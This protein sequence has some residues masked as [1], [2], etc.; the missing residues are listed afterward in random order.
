MV[1]TNRKKAADAW[2]SVRQFS[3]TWY[4]VHGVPCV[5]GLLLVL[6]NNI[7]TYSEIICEAALRFRRP[8]GFHGA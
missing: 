3:G 5:N 1:L 7:K 4:Y 2:C 6:V 8:I